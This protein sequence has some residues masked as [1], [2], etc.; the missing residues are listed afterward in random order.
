MYP[1]A[2]GRPGG[3]PQFRGHHP[4]G[5][6]WFFDSANPEILV[7]VL[8]GCALTNHYWVFYAATTNVGFTLTVTDT[9]TGNRFLRVNPDEVTSVPVQDTFALPCN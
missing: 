8:N 7:K 9:Q 1:N 3:E 2:Q 5:L 6:F 4:G